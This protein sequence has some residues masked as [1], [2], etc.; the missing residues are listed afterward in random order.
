P[1]GDRLT[2]EQIGLIRAWID[3]G[4]NWPTQ[5]DPP[6]EKSMH[7][8]Y[9]PL[10]SVVP[11]SVGGDASAWIR[12]PI[13]AF[14]LKKLNDAG[15]TYSPEADRVTL[16]R[17]LSFDLLGLLPTPDDVEEFQQ[18]IS[19]DA[20]EKLVDRYLSSPRF[21]EH[22]G[23]NWLDKARYA[24]SD[25]YEKDNARLDVWRYRNWV[26]EAIN[27]DLP[28]DRFTIE[29]LA[30]DLLP[31]ATEEQRLA[32]AFHRQ[33]LTNTEGGTD[34]EQFRV[35]ATIDR[36]NTT[37]AVW[38][39]LTVG[40]AQC[41]SH[42]YD[43]ISQAEYYQMFAFFNNGDETVSRVPTSQ[44]AYDRYVKLMD[45]YQQKLTAL[46]TELQ[47]RKDQLL[48]SRDTWEPQL[49]AELP[50]RYE[51][52]PLEFVR[53]S[54]DDKAVTFQKLDDGSLLVAGNNP[55]KATYEVVF[56][57]NLALANGIKLDALA[58]DSLGAKG[59]GRTPHGNFVL[60]ELT[61]FS[62]PGDEFKDEHKVAF[63][64]TEADIFQAE[65]NPAGVIDGNDKTGWAIAPQF[66]QNHQLLLTANG[67]LP[68]P[69]TAAA[70]G[71]AWFR[72]V[73]SQQHGSQHTLGRFRIQLRTGDE[74]PSAIREI[75]AI[76]PGQRNADQ[77]AAL[78]AYY[79]TRDEAAKGIGQTIAQHQSQKPVEPK[80]DVRI[81]AQRGDPRKTYLLR[82]G[83]FLSPITTS[84]L[85]P[86]ALQVLHPFSS[87]KTE[88]MADRLDFA[89]W[90]TSSENP[91]T[92]RVSVNQVW[93][94]LFNRG[95]VGTISDFGVR[96]EPPTHPELF[97][98][99]SREYL[100]LGWSRKE[101]IR[102]IVTSSTYRQ[103]SLIREEYADKDPQ[104]LFLHRQNRFRV[105]AESLRDIS[106]QV[107]GL[108][109]QKIGGPS[110]FP[111]M[112]A[113]VAEI[114]YANNFSWKTSQG[115][116]RYRRGM[117]T[118]FKR[119]APHPNLMTFDCPDS[120]LSSLERINSNTP[121]QALVM[122]NE[123][124]F[125]ETARALG[126]RL[127]I[128]TSK[129]DGSRIHLAYRLALHREPRIAEQQALIDL[130]NSGRAYYT[131]HPEEAEKVADPGRTADIGSA[132][133][134]AWTI[135]SRTILNLDEFVTRE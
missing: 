47:A 71:M 34:Q 17:R 31:N 58:D 13:D 68:K 73:L 62:A 23:R 72:V 121:L 30:G 81:I 135:L 85:Q 10:A 9:Q 119:T 38:M 41:H 53:A 2:S 89:N 57:S 6:L 104:N 109:S 40:C 114:S 19:S 46:E 7:W 33:T 64:A 63:T 77:Q 116:D 43:E 59:P 61:L 122:L 15:M 82:R 16:I 102:A 39:G 110:V 111:P 4:A 92:P 45:V 66:G 100:R 96:G 126:T 8:S 113:D 51:F 3:Q 129:E 25:G 74:L 99:L 101:L 69:G 67:P 87:R 133:S 44:A 90:L 125:L 105:Q 65:F 78:L 115:D 120:N 94:Q 80:M 28:Y 60:S 76:E 29:Q 55:D 83:D 14:V 32:T 49:Q 86:A 84:E 117:Y 88:G 107:S 97:D 37:G 108:L 112:P 48:A 18:D 131:Q 50:H 106:L 132:E 36:V 134:A 79:M 24:D 42:K 11:P 124:S 21:G 22:W 118:F 54:A 130:L 93:K 1:E 98:W 27:D 95:L 128:S 5:N 12:N 52:H 70:D 91:L 56:K 35:E 75:L 103:S 123:E 127:V 26:I 20:Y